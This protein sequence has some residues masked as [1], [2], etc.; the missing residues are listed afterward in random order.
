MR[1]SVCANYHKLECTLELYEHDSFDLSLGNLNRN[2]IDPFF[3]LIH[4]IDKN[5]NAESVKNSTQVL[6]I[7]N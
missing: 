6:N 5:K 1:E 2:N 3:H 7:V 4:L